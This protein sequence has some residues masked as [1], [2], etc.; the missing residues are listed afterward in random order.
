MTISFGPAQSIAGTAMKDAE[1]PQ[2]A[3]S[4]SNVY[5]LWH[6]SPT[7]ATDDP[8]IFF[9]R[10]TNRGASFS[11]RNN[12]SNSAGVDSRD[13]DMAVSDGDVFVVW[14]EGADITFRRST[15]AGSGF[16]NPKKLNTVAGAFR[17]QIKV[18]DD[19]VY[20]VWEAGPAGATDIFLAHSDNRGNGFGAETNVSNT[21]GNSEA[22]QVTV[23]DNRIVVTWRDDSI[24]GQANEIFFAQGK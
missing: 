15:N 8:D 1:P 13:E 14:S 7:D 12:L 6:E 4:G 23:T 11:A 17:P 2:I 3:A 5:I 9:A 21:A 16:S 22:P 18:D 20:V 10:S 24:P 19:D